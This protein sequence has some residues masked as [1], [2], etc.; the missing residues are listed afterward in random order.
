MHI[1]IYFI[2]LDI[3]QLFYINLIKIEFFK[4]LLKQNIIVNF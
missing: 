3:C 1:N 2:N 4:L